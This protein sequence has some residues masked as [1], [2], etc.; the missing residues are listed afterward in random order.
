MITRGGDAVHR[1]RAQA[2][3]RHSSPHG[4]R[5]AATSGCRSVRPTTKC[6]AHVFCERL[7]V[8]SDWLGLLRPRGTVTRLIADVGDRQRLS[9]NDLRTLTGSLRSQVEAGLSS[10]GKTF[11]RIKADDVFAFGASV[12]RLPDLGLQLGDRD[13]LLGSVGQVL[14]REAARGDFVFADDHGQARA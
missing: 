14:Q 12:Q 1:S 6:I 11:F 5:G 9:L 8:R 4:G 13:L 7:D 2:Y 3:R 10:L